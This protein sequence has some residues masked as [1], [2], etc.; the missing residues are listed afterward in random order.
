VTAA[1]IHGELSEL[2]RPLRREEYDQ[3]VLA[4]AF[5]DERIELL[6]G[7]LVEMSPEGTEHAWIIQLLTRLLARGLPEQLA[8][9]VAAPWAASDR[10]EPEPDFA[11]IPTGDYRREHLGKAVLVIEVSRSSLLKDLR[12]M[13][14]IYAAAGV[15][16]YWVIDVEALAVHRH[17]EPSPRASAASSATAPVRP[18]TP[19]AWRCGWTSSSAD[20]PS[21]AGRAR[22]QYSSTVV[23]TVSPPSPTPRCLDRA[24]RSTTRLHL[25]HQEPPLPAAV[26]RK[27]SRVVRAGVA[28]LNVRV[29]TLEQRL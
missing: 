10:S 24:G 9:R 1:E 28:G 7:V 18:S 5:E 20:G 22:M 2:V 13:A 19:P 8:L 26:C 21:S 3:L 15:P 12:L 23:S 25:V 27:C 4:G 6:D 14:R 29:A 17:T 11:V 16:E